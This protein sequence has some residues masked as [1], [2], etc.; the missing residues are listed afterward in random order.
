VP[1]TPEDPRVELGR[2]F[3]EIRIR[4]SLTI[5]G[6]AAASEMDPSNLRT[7][8]KGQ[9]NPRLATILK[10]AGVLEVDLVELFQGLDPYGLTGKDEPH[11]LR[12]FDDSFWRPKDRIA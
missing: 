6:L 5:Q 2:R 9:G 10:L 8:E 4:L 7:I 1:E 3:A 12:S 11:P